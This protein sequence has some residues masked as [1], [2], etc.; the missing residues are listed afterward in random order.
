MATP[1]TSP[2]ARNSLFWLPAVAGVCALLLYALCL[3]PGLTWAHD[4]ADGG[5]LLA[6]AL[7]HGVPHPTGY[8]TYQIVLRAAI[9]LFPGEPA[10]AGNWLS[11]GCAAAATVL[12][13]DLMLRML[14]HRP[15]RGPSP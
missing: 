2:P 3:A 13:A 7:T 6:A 5:D 15:W 12:V 10:R 11:A 9:A 4:G 1:H 14:P 8:P